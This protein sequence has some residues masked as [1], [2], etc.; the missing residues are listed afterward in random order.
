MRRIPH[1]R[2]KRSSNYVL[3]RFQNLLVSLRKNFNGTLAK[4]KAVQAKD[5][6]IV[7]PV[8]SATEQT[9]R[10]NSSKQTRLVALFFISVQSIRIF[11]YPLSICVSIQLFI[12]FQNVPFISVT[13]C[14]AKHFSIL[15]ESNPS[16]K[17]WQREILF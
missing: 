12:P 13:R 15:F 16:N 9:L 8:H 4:L 14:S 3:C 6:N 10:H 1:I 7:Y 5:K 17:C 11:S 2:C